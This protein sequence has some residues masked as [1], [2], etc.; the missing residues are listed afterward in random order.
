MKKTQLIFSD[1]NLDFCPRLKNIIKNGQTID[2]DGNI[3]P[4]RGMST[5]NNLQIIRG[6]IL[7]SCPKK[8]L[9]IGL[10]FGGSALAILSTLQEVHTRKDFLHTAIDPY[11]S[12]A[13]KNSATT[14]I[15]QEQLDK[16]FRFFEEYSSLVLPRLISKHEKFGLVYIDGSHLFEDVFVDFYFVVQLLE[17]NGIVI[18]DDCRNNHVRKVIQFI[19]NNYSKILMSHAIC[20]QGK[21]LPKKIANKLGYKQV[22]IFQKIGQTPRTWKE[23]LKDF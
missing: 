15:T 4:I 21:S 1:S 12:T 10:A 14:V 19:K 7:D 2:R 6:L 9:E 16:N 18:F 23:K 22:E 20:F 17:M 11:Q 8:T 5:I 13:W 3:I